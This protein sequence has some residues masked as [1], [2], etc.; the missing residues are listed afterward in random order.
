MFMGKG[1]RTRRFIIEKTAP[2][3]NRKGFSGTSLADLTEATG[4]TRGSIYGNFRDKDEVAIEAL[5]YN[6]NLLVGTF[7]E[8]QTGCLSAV[9]RLL[10]Y[11][12]GYR[13][14]YP[15]LYARGGCP[16]LNTLTD[17]DD[18]H[19]L[20]SRI[21]R[22]VLRQWKKEI[23][24]T[25]LDGIANGEII[26]DIDPV[27]FAETVMALMEGGSFLAKS[28]GEESYLDTAIASTER[29]ILDA[30]RCEI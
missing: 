18:T 11:P 5:K 4:L 12:R 2:V 13:R 30:R 23:V 28:T 9:D 15:E 6:V 3:F 27:P 22:R 24:Q 17:A 10:A 19:P 1:E 21:A 29:L 8:E 20:L 14:L 16:L 25:V 26:P 7:R